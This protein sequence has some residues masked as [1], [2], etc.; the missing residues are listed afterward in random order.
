M[1]RTIQFDPLFPLSLLL[2][3]ALFVLVFLL[4][5]Q[6]KR[7]SRY[8]FLNGV[9]QFI[10]V[11]SLL[12]LAA[13]PFIEKDVT[14]ESI[15]LLTDKYDKE[16]VD[17]LVKA[18][19][20][21]QLFHQEPVKA[22]RKSSQLESF[23]PLAGMDLYV[24]GEGMPHYNLEQLGS[25][26]FQFFPAKNATGIQSI[27]PDKH[28][29]VNR[30]GKIEGT[31]A[32]ENKGVTIVL[33]GPEGALDSI[34]Y[35]EHGLQSFHFKFRPSVTG[36]FVYQLEQKD[37]TGN[38]ILSEPVPVSVFPERKLNILLLQDFPF[39]ELRFLKNYLGEKGHHLAIRYGISKNID[40]S[41]FVN[42][43]SESL[44]RI[45]SAMLE[46]FDLVI[47][48]ASV[49]D[50][51]AQSTQRVLEQSS[52][53]G[54]GLLL[55]MEG[56][57]SKKIK[58]LLT[59]TFVKADQDTIQLTLE[60]AS[61]LAFPIASVRVPNED[62]LVPVLSGKNNIV[63][64]FVSRA[65][66]KVG[67]QLL[68]ETYPLL[69]SGK[70]NEF[71]QVW[72]PLLEKVARTTE[73]SSQ[74]KIKTSFPWYRDE[75]IE[76]QVISRTANPMLLFEG[77]AVPLIEDPRI[78][79]IWTT[80]IWP[81]HQ[82]WNSLSIKDDSTVLNFYV[83]KEGEWASLRSANQIAANKFYSEHPAENRE[84]KK[85]EGKISPLFFFMVFLFASGVLWLLPKV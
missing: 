35:Q 56:E 75:P 54:L 74:L 23:E 78:D 83:S 9:L 84:H 28:F 66:G 53:D 19:V 31:V 26:T 24:V 2:T 18:L 10:L 40:R 67:F 12:G 7:K 30:F 45:T 25:N 71:A 55:L 32:I 20:S 44:D 29:T 61:T 37:S 62:Q 41:E 65:N 17:S 79:G 11:V 70:E 49:F 80:T 76:V 42:R 8:V 6:W 5:L 48:G 22:F 39:V 81:T 16:I 4:V 1:M 69:L 63:E 21:P 64:G 60:G 14:R 46:Q 51:L 3:G 57:P 38:L 36:D 15:I 13:R 68:T 82:G 50:N 73:M 58:E 47:M 85:K 77:E 27:L 34:V 72:I 59:I 43:N 52:K 33:K